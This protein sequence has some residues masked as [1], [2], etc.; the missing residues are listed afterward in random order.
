MH[1]VLGVKVAFFLLQKTVSSKDSSA[2]QLQKIASSKD[3]SANQAEGTA[4]D[5]KD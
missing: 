3:S 4:E 1:M 2:N 5:H